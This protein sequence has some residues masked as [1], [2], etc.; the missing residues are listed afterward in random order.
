MLLHSRLPCCQPVPPCLQVAVGAPRPAPHA[1][2]VKVGLG[3]VVV[4]GE[5]HG[6]P[7]Q[8]GQ[9]SKQHIGNGGRSLQCQVGSGESIEGCRYASWHREASELQSA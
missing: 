7:A 3:G 9:L 4:E 2:V 8:G 1:H 6:Q 5:G